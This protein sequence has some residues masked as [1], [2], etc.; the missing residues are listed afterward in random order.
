V[1]TAINIINPGSGYTSLPTISINPPYAALNDETNANLSITG[2]TTNDD[3]DYFVVVTNNY[4]AATSSVVALTVNVPVYI[5][6]QPTNLTVPLGGNASIFVTAGGN[7]PLSYQ[8]YALP[9]TNMTATATA[10]V[11]NGFV[12]GATVTSDGAGYVSIPNVQIL[13]GGGSGASATAVVSNETVIAINIVNPGSG[14]I[15][16]TLIQIDPPSAVD[17]T[18]GT[19]QVLNI[20][21]ITANDA[22]SYFVIVTNN[23]GSV[24]STQAL[25]TVVAGVNFPPL[26]L[27]I[28]SSSGN[29]VQLQMTGTPDSPYTVQS[30][31]NLAPPIQWQSILTNTADTN[32]VWQ[33]TDTN[34]TAYPQR[35]YRAIAP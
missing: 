28:R 1:V 19:N 10:L 26:A 4:G 35:F 16:T 20:S 22:G 25:L 32:G 34:I 30:A 23:Y 7:A 24:K 11:L 12:Y 5:I 13:G 14:Y 15:N 6:T 21:G 29:S 8:W 31:T 33:F 3:G 17:L 2:A 27:M 9:A 18:A